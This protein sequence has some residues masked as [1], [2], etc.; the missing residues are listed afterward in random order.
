MRLVALL[1]GT[2]MLTACGSGGGGGIASPGST[3]ATPTTPTTPSTAHT[4]V[5]PT[6]DKTYQANGA[7]HNFQ[8][9]VTLDAED[10]SIVQRTNELYQGDAT[11]V[12]Q[13]GFTVSYSPRDAIFNVKISAPLGGVSFDNRFQDPAH[14]TDFGG[15]YEPQPGTPQLTAA[16]IQY[17][18]VGG[19]NGAWYAPSGGAL[20]RWVPDPNAPSGSYNVDTFFYQKPGTTTKYVTFAGFLRNNISATL[21]DDPAEP[22]EKTIAYN[23]NLTRGAFVF[24]EMTANSNVPKTGS[25]TYSGAMIASSVL[26]DRRDTF[27]DAPTYFQWI[28]GTATAKVDFAPNV[29]TLDLNGQVRGPQS[30]ILNSN[31]YTIRSGATF[32]A[33]GTGHLD[34]V[35]AGGFLGSFQRAWFVNPGGS[36]IDLLIAG[37]SFDGGFYGPRAEEV[38]GNFRIVG[39]TPDERIDILGAFT[40]KQ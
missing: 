29:F 10:G 7:G 17:L 30:D 26:N 32:N 39:G 20:P 14:R 5:N 18:E 15:G 16:G 12:R 6:V 37:S 40:G 21:A 34:L 8:Y 25:A 3:P 35:Y 1:I 31:G 33:N 11:T 4:F 38:G 9:G 27:A 36:R 2:S 13:S 24:G 23:Y 19:I 22:G 28:E